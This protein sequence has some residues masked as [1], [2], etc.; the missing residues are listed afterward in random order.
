MQMKQNW[1]LRGLII[2]KTIALRIIKRAK[3][4]LEE[5][6]VDRVVTLNTID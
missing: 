6:T 1:F 5:C 2:Y 3:N 4:S